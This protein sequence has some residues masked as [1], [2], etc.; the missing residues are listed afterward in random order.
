MLVVTR[1]VIRFMSKR[2]GRGSG[3]ES[4]ERWLVGRADRLLVWSGPGPG[5][6]FVR[7]ADDIYMNINI[8]D[9]ASIFAV[10]VI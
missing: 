7:R 4:R 3:R 9:L 10:D 1:V 6:G 5:H 2:E 8:P